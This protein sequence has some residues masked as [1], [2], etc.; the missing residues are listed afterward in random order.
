MSAESPHAPD[1]FQTTRWTLV[2][3]A[4]SAQEAEASKALNE[5]CAAYWYPVYA[6]IRR[7]CFS[8]EDAQDLT[9]SYFADLLERG[10]LDRADRAK[11]KLRAFLLA[12]IKLFLGNQHR[13]HRAEKR[14]GG[15]VIESFDQALAEKRYGIEPADRNSPDEI[16]DRAWAT[17]LLNSVHEELRAEYAARD[18]QVVFDALQQFIAWNAGD[19]SYADVAAALGKTINDI[20]VSVH[21]LRKRYR[22]LLERAVSDT[23]TSP[24][25]MNDEIRA[26]AAAFA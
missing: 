12:D 8:P 2:A 13:R 17:T 14:G 21:R 22:A 15:Q 6:F 23:V 24:D 20:K 11:G 18:Q 19:L 25:E 1:L 3:K 5:L 4:R 16:F 7:S 26:L 9:Q 10:Y